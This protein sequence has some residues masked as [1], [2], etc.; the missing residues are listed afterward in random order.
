MQPGEFREIGHRLVDRIAESLADLPNRL[1]TPDKSLT[2]LRSALGA[3]LLALSRPGDQDIC[4]GGPGAIPLKSGQ[5]SHGTARY[6]AASTYQPL[7]VV[8]RTRFAFSR[9]DEEES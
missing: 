7:V 5:Y 2:D 3:E 8:F 6:V 1:V 4:P 9:V